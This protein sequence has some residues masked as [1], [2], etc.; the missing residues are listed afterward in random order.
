MMSG[1]VTNGPTP[2]MSMMLSAVALRRPTSRASPGTGGWGA[3]IIESP[4][5]MS[6]ADQVHK[7]A[8]RAGN[9]GRKLTRESVSREDV[10][11]FAVMGQQQAAFLRRLARI[12]AGQ[13]RLELRVPLRHEVKPALLYP[14]VKILLRNFVRPVEDT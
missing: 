8:Y 7:Q 11:P 12:I 13:Q 2:I 9:A 1:M 10:D 3:S 6:R 5:L 14:A 4:S